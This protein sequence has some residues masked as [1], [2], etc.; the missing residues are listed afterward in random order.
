MAVCQKVHPFMDVGLEMRSE[1]DSFVLLPNLRRSK[2]LLK[3]IIGGDYPDDLSVSSVDD[4]NNLDDIEDEIVDDEEADATLQ[5]DAE[6]VE[7]ALPTDLE[8]N[9]LDR[10]LELIRLSPITTYNNHFS[11]TVGNVH[12][13]SL[14]MNAVC[15]GSLSGDKVWLQHPPVFN[16]IRGGQIYEAYVRPET[17]HMQRPKRSDVLNIIPHC[18]NLL[19]KGAHLMGTYVTKSMEIVAEQLQSLTEI[20]N[21]VKMR[22]RHQPKNVVRVELFIAY[23]DGIQNVDQYPDFDPTQCVDLFSKEQV[24]D[25]EFK[26]ID[27]HLKPCKKLLGGIGAV[28][29]EDRL[30]ELHEYSPA[31]RTRVIGSLEI[32]VQYAACHSPT[33]FIIHKNLPV[34]QEEND[35]PMT[36]VDLPRRV[37]LELSTQERRSSGF[38]YGICPDLL[39][40]SDMVFYPPRILSEIDANQFSVKFPPFFSAPDRSVIRSLTK[41]GVNAGM[42]ERAKAQVDTI[43]LNHPFVLQNI[44]GDYNASVMHEVDFPYLMGITSEQRLD[45]LRHL[46]RLVVLYYCHNTWQVCLKRNVFGVNPP[47]YI[48][49]GLGTNTSPLEFQNFPFTRSRVSYIKQRVDSTLFVNAGTEPLTS[50]GT[51]CYHECL[52]ICF[53]DNNSFCYMSWRPFFFRHVCEVDGP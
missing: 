51:R 48:A 15:N 46:A 24:D 16:H 26:M 45:F 27:T 21:H 3:G 22:R 30:M 40:L 36:V 37:R 7:D 31:L 34:Y 2:D 38:Q 50:T 35:P 28:V 20:C 41:G 10:F 19:R 49:D 1:D 53:F 44:R 29:E 33:S 13:S 5:A 9:F 39:P 32:L 43:I 6:D 52:C 14:R 42:F 47:A 4:G 23:S 11:K 18:M 17:M 8:P 25:F 12:S